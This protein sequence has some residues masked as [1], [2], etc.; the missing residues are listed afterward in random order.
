MGA[1]KVTA[2]LQFTETPQ[3]RARRRKKLS[4]ANDVKEMRDL[5]VTF[6]KQYL[7][8]F[9]ERIIASKQRQE[10]ARATAEER[11]REAR[12]ARRPHAREEAYAGAGE[13]RAQC[14]A[15][16]PGPGAQ[17][18]CGE[19]TGHY[20]ATPHR[21]NGSMAAHIWGEVP[22][23]ADE[24]EEEAPSACDCDSACETGDGETCMDFEE[25]GDVA[26]EPPPTKPRKARRGRKK[27]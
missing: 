14:G 9:V 25:E 15:I 7:P 27:A 8:G 23:D 4:D 3:E 26:V 22:Y 12:E 16:R 17:P 21:G 6:A 13:S 1:L 5:A 2:Y 19:P 10:E 11:L 18:L 24:D 20:P